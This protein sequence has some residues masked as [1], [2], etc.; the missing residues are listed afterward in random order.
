MER[1]YS[2]MRGMRCINSHRWDMSRMCNRM[3]VMRYTSKHR[4]SM[5]SMLNHKHFTQLTSIPQS[6]NTVKGPHAVVASHV[7]KPLSA[8]EPWLSLELLLW[9]FLVSSVRVGLLRLHLRA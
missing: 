4:R 8:R 2:R 1:M 6:C 5:S 7:Y 3:R 9:S